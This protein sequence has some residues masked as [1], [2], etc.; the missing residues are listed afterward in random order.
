M[1]GKGP[2]NKEGRGGEG[3]GGEE[4]ALGIQ[5][6]KVGVGQVCATRETKAGGLLEIGGQP[7]DR[8]F[9]AS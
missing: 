8:Q 4:R 7:A 1:T 5:K 6:E 2:G 3:K 9:E